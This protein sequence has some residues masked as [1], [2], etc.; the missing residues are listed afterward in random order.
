VMRGKVKGE[1][2]N[3]KKFLEII[4]IVALLGT[5]AVIA[6]KV[7]NTIHESYENH[8]LDEKASENYGLYA[9][10]LDPDVLLAFLNNVERDLLQSQMDGTSTENDMALFS[11]LSESLRKIENYQLQRDQARAIIDVNVV[12]MYD[13]EIERMARELTTLCG[14]RGYM[15]GSSEYSRYINAIYHDGQVMYLAED[16]DEKDTDL[17]TR[18][19]VAV[20]D[21]Y[22][23]PTV[24]SKVAGS[25]TFP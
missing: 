24:P 6:P 11:E 12:R 7:Y 22:Y 20:G 23:I 8:Q 5:S 14:D 13:D 1:I 18:F 10:A 2:S 4:G 25:V 21:K 17:D 16:I 9:K 15:I 3:L 19:F